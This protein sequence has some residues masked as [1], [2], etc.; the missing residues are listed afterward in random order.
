MV[1]NIFF[2][3]TTTTACT[4]AAAIPDSVKA[5]RTA[6]QIQFLYVQ[7][8]ELHQLEFGLFYCRRSSSRCTSTS[9]EI[10]SSERTVSPSPLM[11]ATNLQEQQLL[12][13]LCRFQYHR[14]TWYRFTHLFMPSCDGAIDS[15]NTGA[16]ISVAIIENLLSFDCQCI[17][18]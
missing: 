17:I 12:K 1:C 10:T 5:L 14:F 16:L 8:Q 15:G 7:Q 13:Q 9:F 18:N 3:D 4:S 2:S 6:G 11:I